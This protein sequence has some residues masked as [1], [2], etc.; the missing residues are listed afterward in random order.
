MPT[1]TPEIASWRPQ[2]DYVQPVES[3]IAALDT[4]GKNGLS[5]ETAKERLHVDG[6][7]TFGK[8]EGISVLGL[9]ISQFKSS[10]I[11]LLVVAAG[12]SAI[13][14]EFLQTTGIAI[15]ILV[16]AVIGFLTDYQSRIS[17]AK[18]AALTEPSV[19]VRRGGQEYSIPTAELV[20]GDVVVLAPGDRVPADLRVVS[21][22]AVCVDES[23]LTGES[24]TVNKSAVAHDDP[25]ECVLFQGTTVSSGRARA[26]VI[27]TGKNTRLGKL[28][29]TIS[30]LDAQRTP[31]EDQLDVLGRK[32][33]VLTVVLTVI[34]ACVGMIQGLPPLVMLETSIA[35]AVAAI[36]EGLPVV[37]TLS[38]AMGIQQMV[39]HKALVRRLPA[40]E[41]LGCASVIC[42]DKTGT[43]TQN[44][45]ILT[46]LVCAGRRFAFTGEGYEPT[47]E[48]EDRDNPDA[49]PDRVL[50]QHSMVPAV[51]CND[52]RLENH[53][54]GWHVHG[55]PTEGALVVAGAKLELDQQSLMKSH[56]RVAELAF[57]L[58]RKR[59]STVHQDGDNRLIVYCKGS[60]ESVL[61]VCTQV[62]EGK[63]TVAIDQHWI[64]WF[65]AQNTALADRGLRVLAIAEREI[66]HIPACI[67]ENT[68]EEEMTMLALVAM[69]DPPKPEVD[70]ALQQC[71]LA[72]IRVIMLTGDQPRTALSIA[73]K[74]G[75]SHDESDLVSGDQVEALSEEE[76]AE[77]VK[78]ASVFARVTPELKLIL[79]KALQ[80]LGHVVSMTGD[81]VN[82]APA[83]KQADIGVAMG[84]NG[85]DLAKD[86]ASLVITDDNFATIVHAVSEGRQIYNK[87][88]SSIGYLLSA[89]IASLAI[90]GVGIFTHEGLLLTPLQLL[91]LNLIMH[92]FPCI[93]LVAQ[94]NW[95]DL[96]SASPRDRREAILN[97]SI[98]RAIIARA[99]AVSTVSLLAV[100]IDMQYFGGRNQHS[101][102]L[103]TSSAA[104]VMLSWTW[105]QTRREGRSLSE[106][107]ASNRPMIINTLI[108]FVLIYLSLYV[109]AVNPVL[110][111]T[112]LPLSEL[113]VFLGLSSLCYVS[114][115]LAAARRVFSAESIVK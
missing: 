18:L 92:V 23:I 51:L 69:Q 58:K 113:V 45:M 25:L 108:C 17:L 98:C 48:V 97:R 60:P 70:D 112:P 83:L 114:F 13:L 89:S 72:G 64:D 84:Q 42:T 91:W 5:F 36:P 90:T 47:G 1:T 80:R 88:K 55:D 79:V 110:E 106:S 22:G 7:N 21:K 26:V 15:A 29:I 68:L 19:R 20:R 4:D 93:G 53:G 67:D 61:S 62:R 104:L 34:F 46:D 49:P 11:L 86:A 77:R 95:D 105:L 54:D 100:W 81:G 115:K 35:L 6:P 28:S 39:R 3:V 87:I 73:R 57:D 78:T 56:P 10:V 94:E 32:L 103:T 16:N 9:L 52:A 109:P 102:A 85:S 76:L 31:L 37:A 59:M 74:L 24:A 82:D 65:K 66:G 12:I 63:K 111:T 99:A 27:A 33:T 101:A 41:A 14:K 30:Q 50:L 96:M 43:L 40:V 2:V 75:I 107:V 44:K 8:D 71:R 38:L